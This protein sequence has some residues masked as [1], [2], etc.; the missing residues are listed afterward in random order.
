[1]GRL[2]LKP[3]DEVAVI[4]PLNNRIATVA[5][6]LKNTVI[7]EDGTKWSLDGGH[8]VPKKGHWEDYLDS[9][10]DMARRR[11]AIRMLERLSW[12]SFTTE[13]LETAAAALNPNS[14]LK[15]VG[16]D[17]REQGRL[18]GPDSKD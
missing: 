15:K 8:R 14:I 9:N 17:E 5:R 13:Q 11:F 10:V 12:D 16:K 4:E 3:G 6:V 18:A 2:N 7:L 1:M